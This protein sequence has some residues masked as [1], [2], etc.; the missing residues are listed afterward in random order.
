[1]TAHDGPEPKAPKIPIRVTESGLFGLKVYEKEIGARKV[2]R[3]YWSAN[4]E[5]QSKKDIISNLMLMTEQKRLLIP[6]LNIELVDQMHSYRVLGKN[7]RQIGFGPIEGHDDFVAMLA[8]GAWALAHPREYLP[9][10][11]EATKS[12]IN[13]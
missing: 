10:S 5:S 4:S 7:R 9:L 11:A 6:R 3:L 12:F 8:E 13:G 1:M 2:K